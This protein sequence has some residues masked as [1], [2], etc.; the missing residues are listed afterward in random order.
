M[1]PKFVLRGHKGAVKSI[2]LL[3]SNLISFGFDGNILNWNLKTRRQTEMCYVGE[4]R[5]AKVW[6][7]YIV[8]LNHESFKTIAQNGD[9]INE[10]K[11]LPSITNFDI[12]GSTAILNLND[13]IALV[14]LNNMN[15]L[16]SI[17]PEIPPSSFLLL[18]DLIIIGQEDGSVMLTDR[19][20]R[21]IKI[22]NC[23]VEPVLALCFHEGVVFSG[24]PDYFISKYTQGSTDQIVLPSNG[25]SAIAFDGQFVYV[26]GWKGLYVLNNSGVVDFFPTKQPCTVIKIIDNLLILACEDSRIYAFDL[27]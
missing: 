8:V 24:G 7:T 10:I 21:C 22:Q 15:V 14:D 9:L 18:D 23:H 6:K 20:L 17:K 5:F 13:T 16:S 4:I 27:L 11:I 25:T 26:S 12:F 2:D 1:K 19:N 3:G